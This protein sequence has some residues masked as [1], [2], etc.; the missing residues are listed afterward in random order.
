MYNA[1][2]NRYV[3]RSVKQNKISLFFL[4]FISFLASEQAIQFKSVYVCVGQTKPMGARFRLSP[5]PYTLPC[6][7]SNLAVFRP[8]FWTLSFFRFDS[9]FRVS[10]FLMEVWDKRENAQSN[11]ARKVLAKFDKEKVLFEGSKGENI[12]KPQWSSL[13]YNLTT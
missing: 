4:S 8:V 10:K 11:W 7:I 5:H 6:V 2:S 9:F 13:M 3:S 12:L 1:R